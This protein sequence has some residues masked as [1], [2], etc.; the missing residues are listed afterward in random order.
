MNIIFDQENKLIIIK[1]PQT[2]VTVQTLINTIRDFED[3]PEAMDNASLAN[4]YGKQDLGSGMKVGITL[5]LIN[6]WRIKFEDRNGPDYILC[7]VSG[8]NLVAVNDYNNNP[9]KPSAFTQVT[10]AQSTSATISEVDMEDIKGAG[11]QKGVDSLKQISDRAAIIEQ[12]ECGRWKIIDSKMIFYKKDGM[13]PLIT[14]NL[15]NSTGEPSMI[16]VLE[17]VPSGSI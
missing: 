16:H 10:I 3:N 15:K 17:R 12:I 1:S 13:T 4:A 6:N 9:I 5:E 2:S 7:S 8:G 11:F 14:F